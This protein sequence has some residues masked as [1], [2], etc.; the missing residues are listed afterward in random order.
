MTELCEAFPFFFLP[1]RV[2]LGVGLRSVCDY[3]ISDLSDNERMVT[4]ETESMTVTML[5]TQV[6]W[7]LG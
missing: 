6:G 1:A 4:K 5:V 7:P 3:S 2:V